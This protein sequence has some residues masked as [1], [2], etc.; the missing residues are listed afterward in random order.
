MANPFQ[1]FQALQNPG[2]MIQN[3]MLQKMQQ[4]NPGMFQKVQQMMNGKSESE[5]KEMAQNIAKERGI[6]LNKFASQFG[7][8]I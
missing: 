8:K 3:Q 2:S 1:M 5:L 4:A 7:M 6:D